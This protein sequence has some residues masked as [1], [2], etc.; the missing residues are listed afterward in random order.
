MGTSWTKHTAFRAATVALGI[1]LSL[2]T[3]AQQVNLYDDR[4]EV[5]AYIDYDEERTIYMW[6]GTPVAFLERDGQHT[7]IF[8]FNSTFLGW[9][10]DGVVLD[11]EGYTVG[12]R[13]DALIQFYS[14]WLPFKGFQ[15]I[16][17]IQPITPFTPLKPFPQNRWSDISLG[18]F[19]RQGEK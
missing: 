13:K 16:A 5:V 7:G 8:G 12:S 9:Y 2:T 15:Q 11:L 17:P 14:E 6:D 4:G 19:L 18:E 1:L 10:E 3:R